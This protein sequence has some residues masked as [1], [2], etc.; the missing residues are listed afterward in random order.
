[1]VFP[2]ARLARQTATEDILALFKRMIRERQLRAGQRLPNERGL[3]EQL[4]VSRPSLREAIRALA[5]M[6]ILEVRPGDGTYVSSL[7]AELLAEPLQLLLAVEESAIF[8]LF[9]VRRIVE[10]ATAS[11]AAERATAD[12]LQLLRAEMQRGIAC[13]ADPEALVYH[14]TELHRLVYRAAHNPLLL[15]TSASLASLVHKARLRTVRLPENAELTVIEHQAFVEA[16]CTRRP[17]EAAEAMTR[18][19]ERIERHL[20]AETTAERDGTESSSG[21]DGPRN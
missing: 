14:D 13:R 12:E 5:A 7:D 3:A 2:A 4:G 10:P 21:S 9:E 19:L 15:A 16:I 6:N 8:S 11:F 17:T 18:H 1:V 20:R